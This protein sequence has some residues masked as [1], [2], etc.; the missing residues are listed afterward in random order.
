MWLSTRPRQ[1]LPH[2]GAVFG[3]VLEH[4]RAHTRF[5]LMPDGLVRGGFL[6]DDCEEAGGFQIQRLLAQLPDPFVPADDAFLN[7]T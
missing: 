5:L 4:G 6:P 2:N 3:V 7:L 1:Y